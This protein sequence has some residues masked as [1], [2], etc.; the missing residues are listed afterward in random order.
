M[1]KEI[2]KLRDA[3]RSLKATGQDGFEGLLALALGRITKNPMRLAASGFQFGVD[4]QGEDHHN[5]VCF[6][7]KRYSS[8][9]SR[10]TV[11]TK[12]ADLGRRNDEADILWVLGATVGVPNQLA[13]HLHA[14]GLRVG[15]ATLV[16]DWNDGGVPA[17]AVTLANAGDDI[18]EWIATRATNGASVQQLTKT[19]KALRNQSEY[20]QRWSSLQKQFS[21]SVIST[22]NATAENKKWLLETLESS[23]V[24]RQRLGQPTAPCSSEAPVLVR[25]KVQDE[26]ADRIQ[27]EAST[28]IIGEEGRGKSWAAAQACLSSPG[29]AVIIGAE[30][31]EGRSHDDIER[32][33][34]QELAKQC[35]D[36]DRTQ[37]RWKKRIDAW[38]MQKPE[39]PFIVV[40]DG[41]NQRPDIKWAH[42][43][44]VL[45]GWL[46][47]RGGKLIVT[48]RPA[49]FR[50]NV[51]RGFDRGNPITVHNWSTVERDSILMQKGI[52]QDWLDPV[53]KECLLNPRLLGIA[54]TVLPSEKDDAW[55]GLTVERLL[56][57]HILRTETDK[58]E[59]ETPADLC[60]RLSKDAERILEQMDK[61]HATFPTPVFESEARAVAESRFFQ[62]I[63]GPHGGY[64]LNSEGL[65]LALGFAV[66]DR[67]WRIKTVGDDLSQAVG[68]MLD[69]ISAVD[70]SSPVVTAALHIC[71]FDDERF[72]PEIFKSLI[73]AFCNLQNLGDEAYPPFFAT[74]HKHPETALDAIK[75]GLLERRS[76]INV[77]WL[78]VAAYQLLRNEQ[79]EDVARK[80]LGTWFRHVNIDAV[81]QQKSFGRVDQQDVERAERRQK[82]I[83]ELIGSFSNSERKLFTDCDFVTG[84]VERL[85]T[86][87]LKMLAGEP[88]A[89]WADSFV[90]LGFSFSLDHSLYQSQKM[91][92]QLTHFN[93]ID[94][95]EAAVAFEKSIKPFRDEETS[96]T[97]RWTVVRM[98]YATGDEELSREAKAI[99]DDLNADRERHSF[100]SQLH[101]YC[102]SDPCDPESLLP[103]NVNKT[104]QEYQKI[105]VTKLYSNMGQS[106][107]GWF[108][109]NAL[110]AVS[111]FGSDVAIAKN[112]ELAETIVDRKE[113]PL[114]QLA[115]NGTA[116][117]PLMTAEKADALARRLTSDDHL[118]ALAENDKSVVQMFMLKF[119]LHHLSG[120]EQLDLLTND[121]VKGNYPLDVI[122][123]LHRPDE[124]RVISVLDKAYRAKDPDATFS[125]LTMV[126][127]TFN[128]LSVQLETLVERFREYDDVLVRAAVFDVA[129]NT[130]NTNLRKNHVSSAWSSTSS[131]DKNTYESWMGSSLLIEAAKRQ[132]ITLSDMLGRISPQALYWAAESLGAPIYNLI[133]NAVDTHLR[134]A[135]TVSGE[136]AASPIEIRLSQHDLVDFSFA[137]ASDKT[138]QQQKGIEALEDQLSESTE[139][140]E[141]RQAQLREQYDALELELVEKGAK[142][143]LENI[144]IEVLCELVRSYPDITGSWSELVLGLQDAQFYWFKDFAF[145]LGRSVVETD[146]ET[147]LRLFEKASNSDAFVKRVFSDGI[148]LEQKAIWSCPQSDALIDLWNNRLKCCDDDAELASEV[149]AA[150]RYGAAEYIREKVDELLASD[151]PIDRSYGIIIAGFSNQLSEMKPLIKK[152]SDSPGFFGDGAR[153]A[154]HAH[155]RAVWSE[156]WVSA[157]WAAKTAEDFWINL[158][159]AGKIIDARSSYTRDIFQDRQF[160]KSFATTFT[161]VRSKRIDIWKKERAKKLLGMEKPETCFRPYLPR[162]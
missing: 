122:P 87:A 26:I 100:K 84:D 39:S 52:Q 157:M 81:E 64:T 146:T 155:E 161:N 41:I 99:A 139:D 55:K 112:R 153:A 93:I 40:V 31:F 129:L 1:T 11:L 137:S 63:R 90:F 152:F 141:K 20:K 50:R 103:D 132:E 13:Q 109:N 107:Q 74:L 60:L 42:V 46:I 22:Q 9:L 53:T 134:S 79:T 57:E 113:M 30:K 135:S 158:N 108:H 98:L 56:F 117:V 19:L 151:R 25:R 12:I 92:R 75:E 66:V 49:Y 145:A 128:C 5:P 24:A 124:A 37:K 76:Q 16:L 138:E 131:D 61:S 6:E 106:P 154:L 80:A 83:D 8:S 133:V 119:C 7:A 111:R 72:D 45:E 28:V 47:D 69:P 85:L 105:D 54:L 120:N 68:I 44:T 127:H 89:L 51:K 123:S 159:L 118:S 59:D 35:G 10:E 142:F 17:L 48:S 147:A 33:I 110:C 2:D 73:S 4:G 144:D 94:P 95:L 43:L 70:A 14:D 78:S 116:V 3:I 156:H 97:G 114:R 88:L 91:F 23:T 15:V 82:E 29:L 130:K 149:L 62:S 71:A 27:S 96:K 148:S 65:N 160:W 115:L 34:L 143:L 101:G 86:L 121:V 18:G 125:A 21:A 162:N 140:F 32:I 58:F 126:A 104:I 77:T 136:L 38:R 150:E 67:L 102:A 36:D